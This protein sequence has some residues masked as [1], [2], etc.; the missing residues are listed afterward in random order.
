MKRFASSIPLYLKANSLMLMVPLGVG[1]IGVIGAVIVPD[2]VLWW[3]GDQV[4]GLIGA[5][6]ATQLL[7]GDPCLVF[8]IAGN[9]AL[10]RIG[11]VRWFTLYILMALIWGM[12]GGIADI[13]LAFILF[14]DLT[15]KEIKDLHYDQ[16]LLV[17]IGVLVTLSWTMALAYGLAA[18]TRSKVLGGVLITVLWGLLWL[19]F[20]WASEVT[21][22]TGGNTVWWKDWMIRWHPWSA[23]QL[24][25]PFFW[26]NRLFMLGMTVLFLIGGSLL[27]RN[28]EAITA[29]NS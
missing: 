24:P 9:N 3:Y 12:V 27:L 11:L 19:V 17:T 18:A 8:L 20:I 4:I 15:W 1:T 22:G 2:Q 6:M 29:H 5:W 23:I 7:M 10:W 28:E 13:R 26:V 14:E 21:V 16:I 25:G